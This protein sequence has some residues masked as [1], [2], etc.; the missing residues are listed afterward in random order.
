M[1]Q[2]VR[3]SLLFLIIGT[4]GFLASAQVLTNKGAKIWIGSGAATTLYV[5]GSLENTAS[6]TIDNAG[7]IRLTGDFLN[8]AGNNT[9][10][11][12]SPGKVELRGGNQQIAGTDVTRFYDLSLSGSGIKSLGV[13]AQVEGTL[14]LSD[15]ELSTDVNTLFVVNTSTSA[16]QRTTGFVSSEPNGKLSREMN[17]V[18]LYTFPLGSTVG[19]PRF[20]P[21]EITPST[22]N[23]HT[24]AARMANVDASTEGYDRNLSDGSFCALNPAFFHEIS[25]TNGADSAKLTFYFDNLFDDNY[26]G[27]GHWQNV[28]Q[29]ENMGSVNLIFN[30]SPVLSSITKN[31]WYAFNPEPFILAKS[32]P[33]PGFTFVTL[34]DSVN[35][36]DASSA[37][38]TG[39]L[40]DFG[41]GNT[42]NLQDPTHT[43][44]AAGTYIV[45]L[46]ASN[47][48]GCMATFCD[49]V[50]IIINN[51]NNLVSG[52]QFQV[53]PN[54][55]DRNFQLKLLSKKTENLS[56]SLFD[57]LG[58]LVLE[59]NHP[60]YRGEEISIASDRLSGG[61]Y[62]LHLKTGEA[63]SIF[64]LN[65]RH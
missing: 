12:S 29:W 25:R 3:F 6:G 57:A 47:T 10:V 46:T 33:T 35:F 61:F 36:T 50:T 54:P 45:C 4:S 43:Y 5:V 37:D 49:S 2:L 59:E 31:A 42:S 18:S 53:W 24:F 14:D 1:R 48:Q 22:A 23:P 55:A 30:V 27:L 38:A 16:I 62:F 21:I 15:R 19:T 7:Q 64:K 26:G 9:F 58:N 32:S 60:G 34:T 20:R 65:V 13:N 40:W 39:W 28:P 56:L 17:A 41:D 63:V 44:A 11:N 8:T 52:V 51:V